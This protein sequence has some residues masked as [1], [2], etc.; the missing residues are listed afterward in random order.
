MQLNEFLRGRSMKRNVCA[1][2]QPWTCFMRVKTHAP[3]TN[4]SFIPIGFFKNAVSSEKGKPCPLPIH[5]Y[6]I[7]SF[8]ML[9]GR[10]PPVASPSP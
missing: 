1:S 2:W 6:P 10:L 5:H 3:K 9:N 8:L 4:G 7:D